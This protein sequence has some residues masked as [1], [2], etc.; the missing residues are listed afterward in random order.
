M[1]TQNEPLKIGLI[2]KPHLDEDLRPIINN[3]VVWLNKRKATAIFLE[4]EEARLQQLLSKNLFKTIKFYKD[5]DLYTQSKLIITLG[6]DGTLIGLCRD[7]P[8]NSAPIFGVNMGRLGFITEFSKSD[9]YEWLSEAIKDELEIYKIPLYKVE[10]FRRGKSIYKSHFLND[11]VI[12]KN[13][14]SRIFSLSVECN[15]EPLYNISGDG[16]IIS[17]PV[18]S[19]AYSLAAGGPIVH[20]EVN[21]ITLTP[22][23]PHSLTH[24]PIVIPGSS[25]VSLRGLKNQGPL[26]LT[27]DGQELCEISKG[28]VVKVSKS[29][30]RKVSIL[31]NPK[32]NYFHTLKEKFTYGRRDL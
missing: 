2:L 24:R 5:K 9:F 25:V 20:P 16:M 26:S 29:R 31:L 30:T 13:D 6:G 12:N 8:T 15:G 10:V 18:G 22:I 14:I 3:L 4:K 11:L 27:L 19:T 7:V 1:A 28:E 32:R 21:S 23:C 17:S